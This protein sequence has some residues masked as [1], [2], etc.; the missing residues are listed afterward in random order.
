MT[1]LLLKLALAGASM[2]LLA[3]CSDSNN[4]SGA[5]TQAVTTGATAS[6]TP[7]VSATPTAEAT[8]NIP[9]GT[10]PQG[11]P[12]ASP[13]AMTADEAAALARQQ[14]A[15]WLGPV[16]SL[17]A[18]V[19]LDTQETTWNTTCLDA[20]RPSESCAQVRTEGYRV[21]LELGNAE[22]EVRTDA[23]GSEVRWVPETQAMVSFVE[24]SANSTLFRTDD[25][26]TLDVQPV[27]GTD[28]VV[29]PESLAEG[30]PVAVGLVRAPQRDGWLLVWMG[31][32]S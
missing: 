27:S 24:A 12:T 9:D 15:A 22:Y 26:S 21:R 14:L 5:P 4:D 29:R 6:A 19:V 7:T 1:R 2:A 3:S 32:A 13:N 25:G 18:T 31:T 10:P 28:F 17:D 16:G 20:P 23:T 30:E 8:P 11:S